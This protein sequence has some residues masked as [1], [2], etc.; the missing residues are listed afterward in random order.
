VV[1]SIIIIK[2]VRV[3]GLMRVHV[4][5]L[6][7]RPEGGSI[8]VRR[9][10]LLLE[11]RPDAVLRIGVHQAVSVTGR[12]IM[13]VVWPRPPMLAVIVWMRQVLLLVEHVIV[14][15]TAMVL[16][17]W[18]IDLIFNAH[19]ILM[20]FSLDR[21]RHSISLLHGI[22]TFRSRPRLHFNLFKLLSR[23]SFRFF[24]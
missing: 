8:E 20:A 2:L 1:F 18:L 11:S 6:G 17:G 15:A 13:S 7:W 3:H 9:K 16:H 23:P 14:V 22:K 10:V 21:F 12:Q 5:I 24:G 4:E 19:E